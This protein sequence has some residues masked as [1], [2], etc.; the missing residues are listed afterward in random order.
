MLPIHTDRLTLRN[1]T[2]ADAEDLRRIAVHPDVGPMLFRFP[3]DWSLD[4]AGAFIQATTFTA[5]PPFRL[6][7]YLCDQFIGSVGTGDETPTHVIYF[8]DPA[9]HGH[10]YGREAMAGLIRFM[11]E[12]LGH[13]ELGA[14]AFNDNPASLHVLR[15]L[16]FADAGQD[17]G[18]SAARPN[19]AP[20]T[21]F[22][23]TRAAWQDLS[24]QT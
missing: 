19:L 23:M 22:R 12:V 10:G 11:F 9:F 8:I 18:Y 20:M 3:P 24:Q 7:V 2:L 16:G 21:L 17:M 14:D 13:A 6:G 4:A 5:H 1:M 15:R